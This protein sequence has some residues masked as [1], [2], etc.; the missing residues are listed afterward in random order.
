M[1]TVVKEEQEIEEDK[2][3]SLYARRKKIKQEEKKVE[4]EKEEKIVEEPKE[5]TERIVFVAR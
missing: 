5:N 4:I 2:T 1:Y 3:I